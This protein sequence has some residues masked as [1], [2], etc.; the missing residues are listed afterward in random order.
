M[1]KIPTLNLVRQEILIFYKIIIP[2]NRILLQQKT[3]VIIED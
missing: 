3:I 2:I 1:D